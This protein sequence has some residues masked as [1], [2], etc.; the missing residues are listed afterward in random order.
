[1]LQVIADHTLTV[2]VALKHLHNTKQ[3]FIDK[4]FAGCLLACLKVMGKWTILY[5]HD[6]L[7]TVCGR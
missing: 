5:G 7:A 6:G 1:M 3:S 4:D 2:C